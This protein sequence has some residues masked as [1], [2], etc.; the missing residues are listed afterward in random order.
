ME[1]SVYEPPKSDL[2]MPS[3]VE[4][5]EDITKKIKRGWIA[6]I[7]SGVITLVL[8]L[9]AIREGSISPLIDI[10]SSVDVA[11]IFLLAFGIYKKSRVAATF[12]FVYFLLA[13]IWIIYVTGSPSGIP[14]AIAFL[15][16]YFNAMI[17]TYRY[18]KLI[19]AGTAQ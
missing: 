17:G 14:V 5:P 6:A 3:Q 19:N 15:Y 1:N 8:V 18:H 16:L 11:L 10:R 12:M 13:K 9:M 7:V 4:I 2:L